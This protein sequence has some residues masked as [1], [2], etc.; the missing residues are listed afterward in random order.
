MIYYI[1][2]IFLTCI[3]KY[4]LSFVST[5]LKIAPRSETKKKINKSYI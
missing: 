4:I 5:M 1:V 3:M 2:L